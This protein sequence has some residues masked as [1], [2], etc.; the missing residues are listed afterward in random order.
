MGMTELDTPR[1]GDKRL[2]LKELT[3]LVQDLQRPRAAIY[4]I[5]L[6]CCLIAVS[7][8]LA[9]ARPFPAAL[10]DSPAAI[11]GFALAT[12]A[13]YRAS[14]FNHELSHQARHLRGFE[15]GWNILVGIPLLIPSFLYSDHRNHHSD[16]SF[17]TNDDVEYFTAGMRGI[18]G[19][20][21]LLVACFILPI[22][23]I[24]RF[25]VLLIAAWVNPAVRHWVDVRASSL[26]ILGL[27][28][29][30]GPTPAE[31]RVWRIQEVACL[32]YLLISGA[33]ILTGVIAL[34]IV[35][36]FYAAIV[37][38]LFFHAM[39][40][41]VG[42][43]Y[44]S[45]GRPRNRIDQLLDSYNFTRNRPLTT[46]MAPL[47]FNLHGLHHLFPNIPYHNMPEAHRRIS[48]A[49]PKNSLYHSIEAPS[50][51]AEVFRFVMRRSTAA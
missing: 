10:A 43:R 1:V 34:E 27:S 6:V 24:L 51:M 45:E 9:L 29:R 49:L 2:P 41:M 17:G 37:A 14:Y 31:R 23:Y 32:C 5:D 38:A 25:S 22:A 19:A 8:G 44:E 18:R 20:A 4:W 16:D 46:V 12:L 40:I 47:G 15:I 39:R 13:M 30:E 11:P 48:A 3:R 50:Y 21:A 33:L 26:G 42:H 36:Q 7:V 35:L 28:R